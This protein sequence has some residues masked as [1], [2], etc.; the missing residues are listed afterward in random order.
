M[1]V[2]VRV[3]RGA[4]I[5]LGVGLLLDGGDDDGEAMGARCIEEEKR[6]AAVTGD[7]AK[8]VSGLVFQLL[9]PC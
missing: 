9:L 1:D 7:Q 8:F 6:E 5:D 4:V 3:G 2:D